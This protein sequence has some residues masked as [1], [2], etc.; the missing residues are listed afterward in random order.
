MC[1]KCINKKIWRLFNGSFLNIEEAFE[2][3]ADDADIEL[4]NE[5]VVDNSPSNA[6]T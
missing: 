5:R 4:L 1:Y 2:K 6:I 3:T